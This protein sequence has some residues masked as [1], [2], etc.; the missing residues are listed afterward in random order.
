MSH[1]L[2]YLT[3][4]T[5]SMIGVL[6]AALLIPTDVWTSRGEPANGRPSESLEGMVWVAGG[7]FEMGTARPPGEGQSNPERIQISESPAHRVELSGFWMDETPVTNAEFQRF[8]EATDYVTFAERNLTK[9]DFAARGVDT[10]QFPA[11]VITAGSLCFNPD[12][13]RTQLVTGV[14]GWEHQ[15]WKVV[16]GANWRR[17]DGPES[18]IDNRL[19]HPVVHI[20]FEDAEAYCRWAGKR[21]PTEAE[22]EF[23][24]RN[25]GEDRR[26]PWG[27]DLTPDGQHMANFWQGE[28]PHDRQN[29][30]GYLTTSPVRAFPPSP[31]G[32]HDIAGNVWEWCSDYYDATYYAVSPRRNPQGPSE[33]YD[34]LQQ[35]IVQRVQRGGSFLCN[36]NN[37]TGYRTRAR[38][39]GDVASSSYHNGFRCVVDES[40]LAQYRAA[41]RQQAGRSLAQAAS[42]K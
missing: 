25:R 21:L 19:D 24:S 31:L 13:N 11:D 37:C 22:F 15:V 18:N 3:L 39:H 14:P 5:A 6:I 26:Y 10:S 16:D 42:E 36:V 29:K 4:G 20:A 30:D 9:E 41:P 34:P 1:R 23:A 8:V 33:P 38:G 17:P 2:I 32:L 40:M 12:Y 35:G 27:D 7:E 28:F